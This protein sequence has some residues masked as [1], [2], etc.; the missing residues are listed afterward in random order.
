M[1]GV[2]GLAGHIVHD[3]QRPT[4]HHGLIEAADDVAA[5]TGDMGIKIKAADDI[6][7]FFREM[8]FQ[9]IACRKSDIGQVRKFL[10]G[11][12]DH[13]LGII[14]ALD[15]PII[16]GSRRQIRQEHA[17]PAAGIEYDRTV[18]Y[19][20]QLHE[21]RQDFGVGLAVAVPVPGII[22]KKYMFLIHRD[23][24]FSIL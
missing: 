4:R 24:P 16:T 14:E 18:P 8:V 2:D 22:F 20:C 10:F 1:D 13:L 5:V 23:S 17:C 15:G 6:I 3:E 11:H 19:P 7:M 12:I 21:R 9:D